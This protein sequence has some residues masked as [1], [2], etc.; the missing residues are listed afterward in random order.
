M[1]ITGR[2]D[3]IDLTSYGDRVSPGWQVEIVCPV[4]GWA[5]RGRLSFVLPSAP[6]TDQPPCAVGDTITVPV[7]GMDGHVTLAN[8]TKVRM[9]G[10]AVDPDA[11]RPAPGVGWRNPVTGVVQ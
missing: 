9:F 11:L 8:G 10:G 2:V 1:S 4:S 3:A 5:P 6:R 7:H